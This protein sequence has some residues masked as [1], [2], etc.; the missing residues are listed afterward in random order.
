MSISV[1]LG[2]RFSRCW[3]QFLD[4]GNPF[5]KSVVSV[6]CILAR[7]L[8]RCSYTRF[9]RAFVPYDNGIP[10][11]SYLQHGIEVVIQVGPAIGASLV[12]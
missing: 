2:H 9:L 8:R 5:A 6:V 11:M 3:I 1:V 12:Y 4:W 10:A 7:T